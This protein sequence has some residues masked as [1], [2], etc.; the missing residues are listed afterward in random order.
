ME[1]IPCSCGGENERCYKCDGRGWYEDRDADLP[2]S[3][4]PLPTPTK[5][6]KSRTAKRTSEQGTTTQGESRRA[7]IEQPPRHQSK[8]KHRQ[9]ILDNPP[10]PPLLPPERRPKRNRWKNDKAGEKSI[11]AE[12]THIVLIYG[13]T[14]FACTYDPKSLQGREDVDVATEFLESLYLLGNGTFLKSHTLRKLAILTAV[15]ANLYV[16]A[17]DGTVLKYA[18]TRNRKPRKVGAVQVGAA[19]K[20][21]KHAGHV[22][23]WKRRNN[24]P[25]GG[26]DASRHPM[27]RQPTFDSAQPQQSERQQDATRD[28]RGF[29]DHGQ[30][31]S[32][33]SHDDFDE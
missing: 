29:R 27:E 13:E 33:P 30:F 8:P 32:H 17:G 2:L 24:K 1:R 12:K 19:V 9:I 25:T 20:E 3:L 15:S 11:K 14:E 16:E 23:G 21:T 26:A 7:S 5:R 31:G 4:A 6:N 10:P 28:F 18:L 22:N